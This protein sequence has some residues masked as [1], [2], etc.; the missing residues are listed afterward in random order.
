MLFVVHIY[1]INIIPFPHGQGDILKKIPEETDGGI[2]M[3]NLAP[4]VVRSQVEKHGYV[5]CIAHY[6]ICLC[7]KFYIALF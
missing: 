6:F 3:F 7:F 5:V 4:G 1:S 2:E